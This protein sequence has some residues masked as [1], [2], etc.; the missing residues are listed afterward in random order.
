MLPACTNYTSLRKPE[1]FSFKESFA[2]TFSRSIEALR[3]LVVLWLLPFT[4]AVIVLT[5]V[6]LLPKKSA[7]YFAQHK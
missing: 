2:F 7:E 3:C 4:L 5:D 1:W 6:Q